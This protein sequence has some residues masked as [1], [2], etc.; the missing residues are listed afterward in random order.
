MRRRTKFLGSI[1]LLL[2]VAV[3]ALGFALSYDA[4][5]EPAAPAAAAAPTDGALMQAVRCRCYGSTEVLGLEAAPR[6]EPAADELLVRVHAAGVNPLD[7]HY[8]QGQPY[9]MRLSSGFGRPDDPRVGV[10]FAGTVEAV[11]RDVQHFAPGDAVFGGRR[12]SY[13]E[14]LVVRESRALA[15]KPANVSFEEAAAV[16]VAGITALQAVRDSGQVGPGKRVLI[17]GA[18]GGVGTYAVQIAKALG[19]HVTGV[20]STRNLELVRSLGADRVIDYTEEDFTRGEERYDVIVDNVGNHPLRAYRRALEPD[21]ILVMVT[22]PKANRWLGPVTRVVWSKMTGPFVRPTYASLLSDMNPQDLAVLRDMMEA[23][24]LRSVIDRRFALEGAPEAIAYLEQGR[25]R[26]KN[27]I[28]IVAD[29]DAPI[30]PRASRESAAHSSR[31]TAAGATRPARRAGIALAASATSP[32]TPTAASYPRPV[33]W[34]RAAAS[35]SGRC[36]PRSSALPPASSSRTPRLP[37]TV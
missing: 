9:I 2:G 10:D 36:E 23:G 8:M 15:H 14:Y 17:N 4:P 5:C 22:G 20:S 37:L 31:S 21:G 24:T 11:G 34:A 30:A 33:A 32:R 18:S 25:T 35:S 29:G 13:A 3:A 28:V 7:W 6:P 16:P 27:V 12:G 19:A 1:V 26:G